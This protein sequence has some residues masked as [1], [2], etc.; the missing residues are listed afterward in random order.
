M[1]GAVKIKFRLN[2]PEHPRAE[3]VN[4]TSVGRGRYRINNVPF[5]ARDVSLGDIVSGKE[6]D[7]ELWYQKTLEK[8]GNGTMRLF[9]ASGFEKGDA[10]TVVD[11]LRERG[12]IFEFLGVKIAAASIPVGFDDLGWLEGFLGQRVNE[13]FFYEI[14]DW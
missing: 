7:G 11:T 5:Y 1:K 4:A 13:N 10:R 9:S 6:S 12:F 8:S 14:S 3:S 2:D